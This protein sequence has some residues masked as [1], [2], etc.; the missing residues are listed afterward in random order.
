MKAQAQRDAAALRI[1]ARRDVSAQLAGAYRSAFR[2]RGLIFEELRDYAPGED[3]SRIDWNATARFGRPIVRRMR[4]ER[5]LVVA[6]LVDVSPSLEAGRTPGPR[7]SAVRRAAAALAT[8]AARA[9]DRVALATFADEVVA[10]LAPEPGPRQLFRVYEALGAAPASGRTDAR[11]ALDWAADTLPRHSVVVLISDMLFP[12]P[13]PALAR[14][15]RKHDLVA[16][17]V[18]DP[19]DRLPARSAPVRVLGAEGGQRALWRSRRVSQHLADARLRQAGAATG[20]LHTG[21]E[22]VASLHH[23]FRRRGRGPS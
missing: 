17:R 4:E 20:T 18:V 2:G 15:A 9:Q 23:F 8:A 3:A 19:S 12:D 22:L 5:D 13:G 21:A 1:R 14:C 16:L 6:L 7:R 10:T 11:C